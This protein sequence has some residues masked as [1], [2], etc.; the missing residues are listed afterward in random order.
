MTDQAVPEGHKGLHGFL[1]GDGGAEEHDSQ[2]QYSF[3]E[4][5]CDCVCKSGSHPTDRC[6]AG[7]HLLICRVRMMGPLVC[8]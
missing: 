6:S 7:V 2:S 3:R 1:Y 8:Q 4:V 5:L